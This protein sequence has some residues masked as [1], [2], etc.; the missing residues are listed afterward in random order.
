MRCD[1]ANAPDGSLLA[2]LP[3]HQ[4]AKMNCILIRLAS[5]FYKLPV[6]ESLCVMNSKVVGYDHRRKIRYI[7]YM[8]HCPLLGKVIKAAE[9]MKFERIEDLGIY[10]VAAA[11]RWLD[12]SPAAVRRLVRS[13][14][15]PGMVDR[16]GFLIPGRSLLEFASGGVSVINAGRQGGIRSGK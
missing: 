14:V 9:N 3:E 7:R 5:R 1:Y 4:T 10:T 11:A 6:G 2:L 15:I 13:G 16:G 12:M 8:P